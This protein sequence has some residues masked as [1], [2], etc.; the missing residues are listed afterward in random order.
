[1]ILKQQNGSGAKTPYKEQPSHRQ[2]P[3]QA[4]TK[5]PQES[6]KRN[7]LEIKPK[8]KPNKITGKNQQLKTT[9]R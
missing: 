5:K 4:K 9:G 2:A 6:P 8:T 1:M 7:K 3:R